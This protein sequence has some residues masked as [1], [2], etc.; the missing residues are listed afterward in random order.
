M[1]VETI[2]VIVAANVVLD[3][4]YQKDNNSRVQDNNIFTMKVGKN[5]E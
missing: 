3:K 1:T 5:V 4:L 2:D